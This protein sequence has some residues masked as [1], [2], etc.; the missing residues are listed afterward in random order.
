M[1]RKILHFTIAVYGIC[2]IAQAQPVSIGT[3]NAHSSAILEL[4]STNSGLLM[5]RVTTAQRNA[6]G[7]VIKGLM[8]F[9]TDL[10]ALMHYNGT[11][12][13]PVGG[14]VQ[15]F[16]MPFAATASL[17]GTSP[18]SITTQSS[19]TAIMG[20]TAATFTPAIEGTAN[21]GLGTYGLFGQAVHASAIGIAGIST[22]ATAVYGFSS[23]GGMAL[24]GTA[25]GIGYA[26]QTQG[27]IRM[28]GGNTNPAPGALLTSVDDF[29][30]AVW[31]KPMSEL[32]FGLA[33]A[34]VPFGTIPRDTWVK[35]HFGQE[36]YDYGNDCEPTTSAS[37]TPGMSSF[38]VPFTG[39]YGFDVAVS[40]RGPT[41]DHTINLVE[42]QI[43]VNRVGNVFAVY[44]VSGNTIHPGSERE[45]R[46]HG[47]T[48]TRLQAGDIVFVNVRQN[49]GLSPA[50]T[51]LSGPDLTFFSGHLIYAE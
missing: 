35:V 15:P 46:T 39:I 50:V 45:Q 13:A 17:N 44:T 16:S 51:L 19:G 4:S 1:K 48:Q 43:M 5:P 33:G 23:N 49:S 24:R 27:N 26:L 21:G 31:K 42:V 6:M 12:W 28:T 34:T 9:D 7:G 8:V 22:D 3:A 38:V 40:L 32:A 2:Q 47:G 11:L 18:F 36:Q 29:G 20:T 37:P 14:T 10:N 30:N 41:P 25:T